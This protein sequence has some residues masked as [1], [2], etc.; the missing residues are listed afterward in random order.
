M[1]KDMNNNLFETLVFRVNNTKTKTLRGI[2]LFVFIYSI[3]TNFPSA[4]FV[5]K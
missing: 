3:I 1:L 2:A 4:Y 5:Y